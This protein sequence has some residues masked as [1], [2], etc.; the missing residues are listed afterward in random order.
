LLFNAKKYKNVPYTSREQGASPFVKLG[1]ISRLEEKMPFETVNGR[2]LYYEIHGTGDPIILL[3][4]GFGCTRIWKEILPS[5][6]EAGHSVLMF[7]RRGYGRSERDADFPAFFVSD[8]FRKENV[9]EMADLTKRLRF[10][11]FHLVG[12]CEGGVVALDYAAR[13]PK[14][15]KTVAISSTLCYSEKTIPEC[16]KIDFPKHFHELEPA[17]QEK[18]TAWHGDHAESFFNQFRDRGGSYG[19]GIFDIRPLLPAVK[20]PTLVLY[21]DRSGLFDVEQ[22]VEFYRHLP[23]GELSVLPM[24]GHNT[25]EHQPEE[26]VHVILR[27]FQRHMKEKDKEK[28]FAGSKSCIHVTLNP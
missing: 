1:C 15:V 14:Q 16:N 21:P 20:C 23:A 24:C 7:D 18:L 17:L 28:T 6:V 8:D 13:Y 3:H 27:F 5:L 11:S 25:Y 2:R 26:Y 9:K 19:T 12:Q 4:H 22:G 10:D